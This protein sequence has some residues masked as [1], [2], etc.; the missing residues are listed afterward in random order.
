VLVTPLDHD[1]GDRV[2]ADLA[3]LVG[4]GGRVVVGAPA[5]KELESYGVRDSDLVSAPEV[6]NQL[7]GRSPELVLVR[8]ESRLSGGDQVIESSIW[9]HGR[10]E[11]HVAIAGQGFNAT[12]G[13]VHGAVA[14]LAPL[15]VPDAGG[16]QDAEA[17]LPQL[18]HA[19]DWR[20]VLL[21][22]D[23][24]GP[25]SPHQSARA[26]YY[27]VLA[28]VRLGQLERARE[29]LGRLQAQWPDQVLTGAAQALIPGTVSGSSR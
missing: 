10:L 1:L 18:A 5:A 16:A 24:Y 7:T 26:L 9:L 4:S 6:G 14:I 8:M 13:A 2:A 23:P 12:D 3:T 25:P 28:H 22:V 17:R 11:K 27:G 19:E 21:L 29:V 20:G 15:L